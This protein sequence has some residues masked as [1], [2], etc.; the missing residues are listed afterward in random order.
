MVSV[1]I[2][3]F[4]AQKWLKGCL[5]SLR[6]Q[7]YRNFEVILVD[8]ASRDESFRFVKKN[9]PEVRAFRK[10]EEIGFGASNNLGARKSR[11]ELLFIL[12]PD[13]VSSKDLLERL[14]RFKLRTKASIIGPRVYDFQGI[15]RLYGKY[16]GMNFLGSVHAPRQ[17]I[18]F[19][20]ACALMIS[21]KDYWELG[22]FDEKYFT[23]NAE[24]DL[25]WRAW[26]FGMNMRMCEDARLTHF[27]GGTSEPT[28]F[29]GGRRQVVPVFRRYEVEKNTLR[30]LLKNYSAA[31][32]LW[33]VPIYLLQEL[34]ESAILLAT[35]NLRMASRIGKAMWWNVE[36]FPDTMRE[37]AR[38]QRKRVVSD[39]EI[40]PRTTFKIYKI[41]ALVK[42]G[43]PVF[44]G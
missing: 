33:I 42:N 8:D 38:I 25:C 12:N 23:Y 27:A 39:W 13:T 30:N 6:A 28:N 40:L 17:E 29:S 37:R 4:N 7:T 1:M 36:N 43:V 26:L 2:A 10:R 19:I 31:N 34:A 16:H 5:D 9:Y 21:K 35:G 20:D 44:K 24:L 3:S 18:F 32:V 41:N 22:G 15:D 14:V 11:G